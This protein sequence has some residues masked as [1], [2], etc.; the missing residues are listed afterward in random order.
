MPDADGEWVFAEAPPVPDEIEE[1]DLLL[2]EATPA[3]PGWCGPA[4]NGT[5][6]LT[7]P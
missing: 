2:V 1:P 4:T 7:G 3:W 5:L 6:A